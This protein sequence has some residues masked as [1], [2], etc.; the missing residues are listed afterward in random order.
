MSQ[1]LPGRDWR[2]GGEA[3]SA[4]GRGLVYTLAFVAAVLLGLIAAWLWRIRAT[5][6]DAQFISLT[7]S[8]YDDPWPPVP[9][10]DSDA[11]LL[12]Q[13]LGGELDVTRQ[14]AERF[15]ERFRNLAELNAGKLIFHVT[16]LAVADGDT[17][18]ILTSQAHPPEA[19]AN[20]KASNAAG[21]HRLD[22]LLDA[23][24]RCPA[25]TGK[26]LILDVAHPVLDLDCG[27]SS[28][29]V[30]ELLHKALHEQFG[31][32]SKVA[33]HWFWS[34]QAPG[35]YLSRWPRPDHRPSPI[36][37]LV[38]CDGPMAITSI[39]RSLPGSWPPRH[40]TK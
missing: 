23:F 39:S 7:L 37:W 28:A 17:I 33:L 26:L 16:G 27:V 29:R 13:V 21:W 15:K 12:H 24:R 38:T 34:R 8:Q 25:K 4:S 22:D 40:K 2:G 36:T 11:R 35:R 18:Y 31:A 1:A 9:Y 32:P 10:A 5:E 14:E 20:W 30:M 3:A 6:A 19:D